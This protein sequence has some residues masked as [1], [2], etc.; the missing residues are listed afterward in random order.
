MVKEKVRK[1]ISRFSLIPEN[2]KVLVALSGGPDSVSLLSL[3]LE[4]KEELRIEVAACHVN[5]G[6]RGEEAERD[7]EF[8]RELCT[9]LAVPL[10]VKRVKVKREG[11]S[12]EEAAREARYK[13]LEEALREWGGDLIALG[14]TSSDLVETVLLNL[15]KGTGLKGL[16]GFLPKRGVF[17]RPFFEVS[18]AEVEEYLKEKGLP[19]VLDSSNLDE[20]LERNLLRL[21]VV[22]HLK[23]INPSLEEAFLRASQVVREAEDFVYSQ[24]EEFLQ[25]FKTGSGF[26]VPLKEFSSLHP[27]LKKLLLIEAYRRVS[28]RALSQKK[29]NQILKALEAEGFKEFEPDRGFVIQKG[30]DFITLSPKEEREEFFFLLKEFPCEVKTPLGL[31]KFKVN[32]GRP[33]AG[34]KAASEKGIIVRSRRAGDRLSFKGF[35]KP[36]KKFL[37][38]R[39]V[40]A[41][42]RW[43]L[44]VVEFEGEIVF[45]PTLYSK[46]VQPEEPFVGVEFEPD[47]GSDRREGDREE[48]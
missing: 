1:T 34:L 22:P 33:V 16:R 11:K 19:F 17:V 37:I 41:Q 18:R 10:I 27:L 45:I 43:K 3:L 9:R 44:P 28:G 6:L 26:K 35:S 8:V 29:L 48:S 14:H 4:L 31:L 20:R 36:L 13:A 5:H 7:E 42:E 32:A 15:T 39:R 38:E 2:S 46:P 47:R 40:P 12:L 21:R 30:Q 25:K 23:R 24:V